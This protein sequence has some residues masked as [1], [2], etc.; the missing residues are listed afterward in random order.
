MVNYKTM[1]PAPR[2]YK[3]GPYTVEAPGYEKV[4]G[5]TIPRRNH[6]CKDELKTRPREEIGT[7]YDILRWSTKQYGNARLV[8]QRKTINTHNEVKKIKK[9]VDGK[10]QEVD[11][12][13]TY[14][15]LSEYSYLSFTEFEK[16]SLE[17]G[18]GLR[19]LGLNKGDKVHIFAATRYAQEAILVT[20]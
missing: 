10:E 3:Y 11:K 12:K 7:I 15:E 6:R 20:S 13:W 16:L 8:G 5:E 19:K 9:M 4:E 17:V 2:V 18:S 1:T 14:F